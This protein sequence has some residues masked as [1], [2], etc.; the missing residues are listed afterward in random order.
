MAVNID[1][2]VIRRVAAPR[3]RLKG[4][5]RSFPGRRSIVA[6]ERKCLVELDRR[7]ET[8]MYN[9]LIIWERTYDPAY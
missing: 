7:E 1:I 8:A 2:D 3:R 5:P 4:S 9:P 6:G